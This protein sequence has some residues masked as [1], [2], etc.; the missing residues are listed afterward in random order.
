MTIKTTCDSLRRLGDIYN[1]IEEVMCLP[2]N[3]VCSSQ[4]KK[5]LDGEMDCSLE[6]LDLCN[7]M[8]EDFAELKAIIQDLQVSL[9]KGDDTAIEAKIKTYFLLVKKAKK[10]FKKAAKK[11]AS[12][13]EDCRI[14]RVLSEARGITTSL[15]ESTLQ[16]LAKQIEMPK[17]SIVSK[18]FQKKVSVSCKEEQLQVLEQII[19]NLED[20]AGHLF[21]RL[22]Q[23]RVTL[24]NI[25]ST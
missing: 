1:S 17:R 23:S 14:L 22:V 4:Q 3:Q 13:K 5:M 16:L 18:A 21:R 8:H 15:L 9:R 6:L 25:F 20:G 2:R 19:K 12:D 11:V 7:A 24:L 10:H